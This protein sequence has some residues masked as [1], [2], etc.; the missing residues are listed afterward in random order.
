M[1]N[2][3]KEITKEYDASISAHRLHAH[4]GMGDLMRSAPAIFDE[5]TV[6]KQQTKLPSQAFPVAPA[7]GGAERGAARGAGVESEKSAVR[8]RGKALAKYGLDQAPTRLVTG[9]PAE[10]P[11]LFDFDD[12]EPTLVREGSYAGPALVDPPALPIELVVRSD[13]WYRGLHPAA[14][15]VLHQAA[16]RRPNWPLSAR[17]EHPVAAPID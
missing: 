4:G 8:R 9:Q 1:R 11:D 7:D 12:D 10:L 3:H 15:Q 16:Q 2:K 5:P 17:I 14:Q 6:F 13:D